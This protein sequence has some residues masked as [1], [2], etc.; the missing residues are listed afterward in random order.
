MIFFQ[1]RYDAYQINDLDFIFGVLLRIS[2]C[3][4]YFQFYFSSINYSS[5]YKSMFLF[6]DCPLNIEN[7]R[8]DCKNAIF[9]ITV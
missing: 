8:V 3:L 9:C 7:Q 4:R 6:L 5:F 2:I 1:T